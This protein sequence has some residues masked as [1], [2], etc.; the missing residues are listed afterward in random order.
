MRAPSGR[1]AKI[2]KATIQFAMS[3]CLSVCPPSVGMEEFGSRWTDFREILYLESF[4]K[5]L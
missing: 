1:I 3:V 2:Q 5:M 4:R